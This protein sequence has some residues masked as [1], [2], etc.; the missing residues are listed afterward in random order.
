MSQFKQAFL[1]QFQET[2]TEW[3]H[4]TLDD[5]GQAVFSYT[6]KTKQH[7]TTNFKSVVSLNLIILMI[8]LHL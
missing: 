4:E 1:A 2:A 5:S 3:Q 7:F 6:R 8:Q